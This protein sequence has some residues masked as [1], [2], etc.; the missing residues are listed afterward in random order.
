MKKAIKV[1]GSS[2]SFRCVLLKKKKR[3]GVLE[4]GSDNKNIGPKS[5]ETGDTTE[6]ESINMKEKCLVEETSF[7]YGKSSAFA[8]RNS[9]QTPTGSKIKTKKA[10]VGEKTCIIDYYPVFYVWTRCIAVCF[11]SAES[12]DAVMK[13]TLVLKRANL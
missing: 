7:N 10:L 6:S 4:N 11:D 8:E 3:G 1:S 2:D 12:L 5:L 13:T 9:N